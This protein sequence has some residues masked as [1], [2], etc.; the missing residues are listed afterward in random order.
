MALLTAYSAIQYLQRAFCATMGGSLAVGT[1]V[2]LTVN[3]KTPADLYFKVDAAGPT[4]TIFG[5]VYTTDASL[6]PITDTSPGYVLP[7]NAAMLL[8]RCDNNYMAGDKLKVKTAD[9]KF[10][11]IAMGEVPVVELVEDGKTNDLAWGIIL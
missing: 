1:A 6:S 7:T 11:K 3:R 8:V 5:V 4:D 10:G 2:K 9:G